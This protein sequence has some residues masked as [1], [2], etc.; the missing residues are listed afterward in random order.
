[1]LPA[2]AGCWI[3]QRVSLQGLCCP[4]QRCATSVTWCSQRCTC[5]C[6]PPRLPLPAPQPALC[7][8]PRPQA[9]PPGWYPHVHRAGLPVSSP[10]TFDAHSCAQACPPSERSTCSRR[11]CPSTE[12]CWSGQTRR[13]QHGH[14]AAESAPG[15][16]PP[17]LEAQTGAGERHA[18]GGG[19][20]LPMLVTV[21]LAMLCT[22]PARH[23]RVGVKSLQSAAGRKHGA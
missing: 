1:M 12:C 11:G 17:L 22:V 14:D 9:S 4:P 5:S 21:V 13:R 6:R 16:P 23:H 7:Q 15:M 18:G 3:A 20:D 19:G 10:L 8:P 2:S